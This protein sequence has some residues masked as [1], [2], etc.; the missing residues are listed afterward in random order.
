MDLLIFVATAVGTGLVL[1]LHLDPYK[2][3]RK[4]RR[5]QRRKKVTNVQLY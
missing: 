3:A 2:V 4:Q 1:G 5:E